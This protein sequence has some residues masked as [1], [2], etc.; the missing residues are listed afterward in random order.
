MINTLQ[1]NLYVSK[2]ILH[3]VILKAK[4]LEQQKIGKVLENFNIDDET[5]H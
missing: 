4:L 1:N 2:K 5:C 3:W